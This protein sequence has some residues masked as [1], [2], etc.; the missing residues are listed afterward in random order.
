MTTDYT[1]GGR[2]VSCLRGEI[3]P[4]IKIHTASTLNP[5]VALGHQGFNVR[6]HM[7]GCLFSDLGKNKIHGEV[8]LVCLRKR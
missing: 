8:G 7:S 4:T 3:H 2:V 5:L 6:E 1:T